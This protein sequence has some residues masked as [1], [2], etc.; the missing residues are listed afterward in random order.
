VWTLYRHGLLHNDLLQHGR[1]NGID[2]T[3]GVSMF[4]LNHIIRQEVVGLDTLTLYND[5]VTFLEREVAS[6][7]DNDEV[8]IIRGVVW[9]TP[10]QEII[11]EFN[12]IKP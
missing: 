5:L 1:Y 12:H 7:D 3:W 9:D 8:E 10:S 6:C 2:A 11:D 4:G